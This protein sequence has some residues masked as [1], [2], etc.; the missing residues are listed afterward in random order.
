MTGKVGGSHV[1][2]ACQGVLNSN[3]ALWGMKYCFWLMELTPGFSSTTTGGMFW[4]VL[5]GGYL[6]P[7]HAWNLEAQKSQKTFPLGHRAA[8]R[9][10]VR[11]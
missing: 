10:L 5:L 11:L 3:W 4:P 1:L 8:I 2:G 6:P 9:L 7:P